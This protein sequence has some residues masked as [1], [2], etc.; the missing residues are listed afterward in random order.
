[1]DNKNSKKLKLYTKKYIY[2]E[3]WLWNDVQ[4]AKPTENHA[5]KDIVLV[6]IDSVGIVM[7]L[8][9]KLGL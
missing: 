1:V 6:Q 3:N 4:I 7:V 2:K 8:W 5:T 9:Q